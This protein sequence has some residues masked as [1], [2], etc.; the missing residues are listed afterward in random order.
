MIHF[1]SQHSLALWRCSLGSPHG[2]SFDPQGRSIARRHQLRSITVEALM[3][4]TTR[5]HHHST[6]K[7][8]PT[9]MNL[10]A[11]T[12]IPRIQVPKLSHPAPKLPH[13][14]DVRR[15]GDTSQPY[16]T[17][18]NNHDQT[19]HHLA[20]SLLQSPILSMMGK[21]CFMTSTSGVQCPHCA[22]ETLMICP[23]EAYPEVGM[24][25]SLVRRRH[26]GFG[27]PRRGLVLNAP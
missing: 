26:G 23:M 9:A 5:Q 7:Q 20:Y 1:T 25:S 6:R 24:Q 10:Q 4:S 18:A 14:H 27:L 21:F 16:R 8:T 11:I 22:G 15:T 19:S 17:P 13:A 12:D 3:T 2:L